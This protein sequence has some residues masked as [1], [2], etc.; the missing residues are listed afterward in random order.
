[1]DIPDARIKAIVRFVTCYYLLSYLTRTM[2]SADGRLRKKVSVPSGQYGEV[3]SI[4]NP[5]S[6][7]RHRGASDIWEKPLVAD[8]PLLSDYN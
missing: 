5:D 1:M 8:L 6:T 7:R 3:G 4:K 2:V